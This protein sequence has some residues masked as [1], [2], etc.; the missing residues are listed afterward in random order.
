[1]TRAKAMIN[2]VSQYE[3]VLQRD[4]KNGFRWTDWDVCNI[5]APEFIPMGMTDDTRWFHA[6]ELDKGFGSR[7]KLAN[8]FFWSTVDL[9]TLDAKTAADSFVF[10]S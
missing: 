6:N 2:Y 7:E 4:L 1:M 3:N 10:K 8:L 5:D 9:K